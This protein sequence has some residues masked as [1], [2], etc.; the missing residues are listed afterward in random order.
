MADLEKPLHACLLLLALD[1]T[2]LESEITEEELTSSKP[3]RK[4]NLFNCFFQYKQ[5]HMFLTC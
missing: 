1:S 4:E 5:D 3:E 2:F